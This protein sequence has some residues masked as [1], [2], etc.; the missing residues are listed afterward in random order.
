MSRM[1]ENETARAAK[2]R[3]ILAD[4]GI[5]TMAT[6]VDGTEFT[7]DGDMQYQRLRFLIIEVKLEIG[8]KGAE[9]LFQAIWYYLEA[10]RQALKSTGSPLP[11]F[12]LYLFGLSVDL[13]A[14]D[15]C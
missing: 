7:T 3:E 14:R 2:F 5:V 9:P 11:C 10:M 15:S 8:S 1:Y 13:G 12:I 4:Y 6:K